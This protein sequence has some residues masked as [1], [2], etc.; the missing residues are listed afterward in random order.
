MKPAAAG[1][2]ASER[3]AREE[4]MAA[5]RQKK[6]AEKQ[7]I[8]AQAEADRRARLEP[9]VPIAAPAVPVVIAP[10]TSMPMSSV[11]LQLRCPQWSR[12]VIF[13]QFQSNNTLG[14]VRRA[15]REDLVHTT[16]GTQDIS[17][18]EA[19]V[20]QEEG[21]ILAEQVPP[22]RKFV[23]PEDMQITLHAAGLC[24]SGTLLVDAA[25]IKVAL[26]EPPAP[27]APPIAE[28]APES[29][30]GSGAADGP[31]D[32]GED[33][34]DDD[35]AGDDDYGNGDD[36]DDDDSD[37]FAGKGFGKGGFGKG[38]PF[39]GN[40][41]GKGGFGKGGF[42]KGGTGSGSFGGMW[43]GFPEEG[44]QVLGQTP[45]APAFPSTGGQSTGAT[46]TPEEIQ[47]ARQARLAALE[48]RM[49]G[50]AK[51]EAQRRA[52]AAEKE[53]SHGGALPMPSQETGRIKGQL[54]TGPNKA[55]RAKEREAILRQLEEDRVRYE[56]RHVAASAV[57]NE[58]KASSTSSSSAAVR[59][60]I[61]CASSGQTVTLG[62]SFTPSSTLLSVRDFAAQELNLLP[63]EGV[64]GPVI[65]LAF[66]PRTEFTELAQLQSTLQDLG[67]TPSATLLIKGICAEGVEIP[68]VPVEVHEETSPPLPERS[69]EEISKCPRGCT[70]TTMRVEEEMWCD[71]C[72]KALPTSSTAWYCSS[73]DYI[74]C[75]GCEPAA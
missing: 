11:R 27:P 4:E 13:T 46:S 28:A 33:G 43:G 50:Q 30:D 26:P 2:S 48:R 16:A 39:A 62:S 49:E 72:S 51:E 61:R 68:R 29:E 41:F 58:A 35:G 52:E 40:G 59:L 15:L 65:S 1:L 21:I 60:Q 31:Q 19:Q 36:D 55:E 10:P 24:P 70:M 22:R 17:L 42:G 54:G 34:A 64:V 23:T 3:K 25:P 32:D 20:P 18:A 74:Q 12:N 37:P 75:S 71:K 57:Q 8:L 14:D 53:A 69:L 38:N 66:P 45:S 56:E 7:R 44:G 5:K 63:G 6:E 73:C 47:A 67:L 9:A